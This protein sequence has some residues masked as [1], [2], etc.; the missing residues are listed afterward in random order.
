MR[1]C[2]RYLENKQALCTCKSNAKEKRERKKSDKAK[3]TPP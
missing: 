3:T 1:V 2:N